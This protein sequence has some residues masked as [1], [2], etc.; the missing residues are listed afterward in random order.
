ML[1][2]LRQSSLISRRRDATRFAFV[3]QGMRNFSTSTRRSPSPCPIVHLTRAAFSTLTHPFGPSCLFA[4]LFFSPLLFALSLKFSAPRSYYFIA[5]AFGEAAFGSFYD[6][7]LVNGTGCGYRCRRTPE[8]G[9][10]K[11]CLSFLRIRSSAPPAH[12]KRSHATG[13]MSAGP[14][15]GRELG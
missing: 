14:L 9:P 3:N 10:A 2:N 11:D 12:L 7:E 4:C 6:D 5:P 8:T 13:K 15:G 1:D